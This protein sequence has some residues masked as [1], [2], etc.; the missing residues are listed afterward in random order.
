MSGDPATNT[1]CGGCD[2]NYYCAGGRKDPC[3]AGYFSLAGSTAVTDCKCQPNGT[4]FTGGVG[5][6][7][8]D[9]FYDVPTAGALGGAVCTQC[10]PNFH[11][12]R[13]Q[14]LGC[15]SNSVSPAGSS[16]D[17]ACVCN[18]GYYRT[19]ATC[20][21]CPPNSYCK[22][23]LQFGCPSNTN[24]AQGSSLATHC[25]CNA[26]FRC[27]QVRDLRMA[28]KFQLLFADFTAQKQAAIKTKLAALTGVAE[29]AV[30][31][32]AS[33]SSSSRRRRLMALSPLDYDDD[34]EGIL[35]I[36]A[37]ISMHTGTDLTTLV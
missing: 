7:C 8:N 23:G 4:F 18:S 27:R 2:P 3:T 15:P 17:A 16:S 11:C 10:L 20:T 12:T 6:K 22:G 24:S 25:K 30:N 37:H 1:P 5:C 31:F 28:I 26:G 9:G 35:E 19:S 34:D 36:T 29:S 14:S 21:T 13:S 33:V 32:V